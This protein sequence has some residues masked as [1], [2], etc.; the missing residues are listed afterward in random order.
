MFKYDLL[1]NVS[2]EGRMA[3]FFL[4]VKIWEPP[5]QNIPTPRKINVTPPSLEIFKTMIFEHDPRR[6]E[7]EMVVTHRWK[8]PKLIIF[9]H[10]TSRLRFCCRVDGGHH[11]LKAFKNN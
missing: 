6:R 5:A 2:I 11:S 8:N 3:L 1:L 7:D 10:Y 4:G 9:E